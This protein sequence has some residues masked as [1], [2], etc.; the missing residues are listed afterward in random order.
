MR[1]AA[2]ARRSR[3]TSLAAGFDALI[4]TRR[5]LERAPAAARRAAAGARHRP[6]AGTRRA[7]GRRSRNR[8]RLRRAASVL[9]LDMKRESD[10]LYAEYLHE[11]MRLSLAGLAAIAALLWLALR[12]LSARR[13]VLAPLLLAVLDR[14]G[15]A[16]ALRRELTILHLV[17]MLLIVAVGSNYALVLRS[18]RAQADARCGAAHARLVA[19]SPIC[20]RSSA[21]ACSPSRRAGARGA[22][23]DGRAGHVPG[24]AVSPALARRR[25]A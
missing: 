17:G 3:G 24:A 2:H 18:P 4:C 23:H 1:A 21:S 10:A 19:S 13:C 5:P 7:R 14:R 20:A 16:R 25:R 12:S 22:G 11:A 15:G 8:E 6:R 9:V